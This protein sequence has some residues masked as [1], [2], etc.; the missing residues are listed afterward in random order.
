MRIGIIGAGQIGSNL[1]RKLSA[2][3][4]SVFVANSREPDTIR[5]IADEAG[6]SAV[7]V[8]EVVKD[9][10]IVIIAIP[11]RNVLV[12]P[13]DLFG[14]V[15]PDVIVVDTGNYYP[16]MREDAIAEIKSG[17]PESQWVSQQLGRPVVKAFNTMLAHS[18]TTKGM[19]DG[20]EGRIA[21]PVSGDD[22]RAKKIVIDLIDAI[23]FDGIDAGTIAE[24][25]RQQPGTPACCSDLQADDLRRALSMAD[26]TQAPRLR[27][28][29]LQKMSQ[30]SEGFTIKDLIDINRAIHNL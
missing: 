28:L 16:S 26:K 3:G 21:L 17:M 2:T 8:A 29:I 24:S 13:K 20:I 12:L 27:D 18:L 1:A 23:G 10:D 22:P 4:H 7:T 9:V 11:E 5:A 6:A 19:P 25:W 30:L 14:E 15:S